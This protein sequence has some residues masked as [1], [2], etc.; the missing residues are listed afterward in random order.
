MHMHMHM[1]M[2]MRM[3]MHMFIVF[4]L[5][6]H[7]I[8]AHSHAHMHIHMYMDMFEAAFSRVR[9]QGA[10]WGLFSKVRVGD[11]ALESEVTRRGCRIVRAQLGGMR[12]GLRQRDDCESSSYLLTVTPRQQASSSRPLRRRAPEVSERP[13]WPPAFMTRCVSH[14]TDHDRFQLSE[15]EAICICASDSLNPPLSISMMSRA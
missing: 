14:N 7:P 12:G 15:E 3:R 13:S 10:A 5:N 2:H 8:N 4:R 9:L 6:E 11:R 1:H